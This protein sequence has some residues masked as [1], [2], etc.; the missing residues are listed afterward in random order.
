VN[1]LFWQRPAPLPPVT[2]VG[3]PYAISGRGQHL[4]AIFRALNA[5]GIRPRVV[6]L[7]DGGGDLSD[8]ALA[9]AEDAYPGPGIRLFHLNGNEAD[10]GRE[11]LR[12]RS[13]KAFAAGH[14]IIFPAWELPRYPR[15]WARA[16]D[17]YDEVWAATDFVYQSLRRARLKAPLHHIVNACQPH[18]EEPLP[19]AHFGLDEAEFLVLFPFD[20]YSWFTRKNPLA[21]IRVVDR[22]VDSNPNRRLRLVI[23]AN[24]HAEGG[25][26]PHIELREMI[27][28]RARHVTLIERP[29][30]DNE[31]KSLIA[32]CD[33]LLSLHRSEGFGRTPA[34]A[35]FFG[36]PTIATGWSG[37]MEYMNPRVSVPVRYRLVRVAPDAYLE[38]RRQR[39]AEPDED[40]AVE[41]LSR[42]VRDPAEAR[43]L[44]EAG[45]RHM[46][47][48]FSDEVLGER[49]LARFRAIARASPKRRVWRS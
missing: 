39:W 27:A 7:R 34:E 28:R 29:M 49:Y 16:L 24:H 2:L 31:A 48:H 19:R 8:E 40:H 1:L 20:Y 37:N 5:V 13:A 25:G 15:H 18:I 3:L 36:K 46:L 42:L 12:G 11:V 32:C 6:N 22:V 43:R 17:R 38:W 4:R 9:A 35:M 21:A 14:N 30:D 47:R 26:A 23:K 33:C 10:W 44:G 41:A 45:R